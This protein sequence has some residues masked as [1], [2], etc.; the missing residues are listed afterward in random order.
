MSGEGRAAW[1]KGTRGEWWV[2]G[3][4]VLMAAV[5]FAPAD[6]RWTASRGVW[7]APGVLLVAVGLGFAARGILDLGPS[8][9]PF[10][11]PRRDAILV[12]TGTFAHVRHP[13]YGGLILASVGWALWRTSGLHVALTAALAVYLHAKARHEEMLLLERFPAYAAYRTRT[14]QLIPWIF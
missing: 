8:L 14:K 10:P 11:R 6:W 1:W 2:V 12:Q 5:V 4:L 3:Q 13:I 7:I 9:S